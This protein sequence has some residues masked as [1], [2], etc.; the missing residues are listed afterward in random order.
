M[1]SCKVEDIIYISPSK[2][3]NALCIVAHYTNILM[4]T[5]QVFYNGILRHVGILELIYQDISELFLV[6]IEYLDVL[7]KELISI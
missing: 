2:S 1:V 5:C 6:F 4:N 3:I 7:G